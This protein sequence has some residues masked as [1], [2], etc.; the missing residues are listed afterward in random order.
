MTN[1]T[2]TAMVLLVL[3]L[4]MAGCGDSGSVSAP[5][6]PSPVPQLAAPSPVP[7]PTPIRLAVFRDPASEFSTSDVRDVQEQVV[8]FNTADELIWTADGTRFSEWLVDGSFIGYHHLGDHVFQ[9][10]FGTKDGERR[11]YLTWTDDRLRGA[12]ATILDLWV[13]GRGDLIIA[14]TSVPVPG[15]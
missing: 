2:R 7:Q 14:E 3:I 1:R 15:R 4:G 9:V 8:H 5:S 11:A 12:A 6:A 10:R 13:D